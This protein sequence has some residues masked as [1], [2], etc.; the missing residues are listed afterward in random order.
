ME[1]YE[2]QGG[3]RYKEVGD[4]DGGTRRRARRMEVQGGV[5][6]MEV[7]G[8]GRGGWRWR[9]VRRM[10]VPPGEEDGG[11]GGQGG[12]RYEEEASYKE[13]EEAYEQYIGWNTNITSNKWRRM[14]VQGGGEEDGGT[15]RRARRMEV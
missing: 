11:G 10:E 15:R 3:W 9:R 1:A 6:R 12:W 13:I 14:E 4:E 5:R 8:G 7:R 2:G